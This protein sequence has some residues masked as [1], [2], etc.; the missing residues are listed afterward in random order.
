MLLEL[1]VV[2]MI[3]MSLLAILFVGA[4]GWKRGS[5][6]AACIFKMRNMQVAARSYQNMYGY[7][8]GGHLYADGRT[9]HIAAHL[10]AKGCIE[11][12]LFERTQGARSC[13]SDGEY[14][15]PLTDRFPPVGSFDMVCSLAEGDKHVPEDHADW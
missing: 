1:T 13:P 11:Q 9:Q 5:D 10:L 6:R 8:S 3:L 14:S 4:Q 7:N 15:T 12:D 2:M